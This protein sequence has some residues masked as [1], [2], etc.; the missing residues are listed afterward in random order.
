[1]LRYID[2]DLIF[3]ALVGNIVSKVVEIKKTITYHM[4]EL[5]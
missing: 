5:I 4:K 3:G 1:M 2:L